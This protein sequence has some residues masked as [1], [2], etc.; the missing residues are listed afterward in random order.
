MVSDIMEYPVLLQ[1]FDTTLFG[2]YLELIFLSDSIYRLY[3]SFRIGFRNQHKCT[4]CNSRVCCICLHI[5]NTTILKLLI[6][7]IDKILRKGINVWKQ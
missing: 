3:T 4:S 6:S 2:M 5:E 1:Y 7:N